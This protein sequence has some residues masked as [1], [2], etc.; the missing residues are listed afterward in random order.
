MDK[1][2]TK[3][4]TSSNSSRVNVGP[5]S[6][7]LPQPTPAKH[8]QLAKNVMCEFWRRG[9]VCRFGPNCWYAHGPMQLQAVE[10]GRM[11]NGDV[12][13]SSESA[14]Q[15]QMQDSSMNQ[16]TPEQ[17]QW[18]YLSQQAQAIIPLAQ[19][20]LAARL[21]EVYQKVRASAGM[22]MPGRTCEEIEREQKFYAAA[23]Q[24]TDSLTS[25][26]ASGSYMSGPTTPTL[27]ANWSPI[28]LDDALREQ[29]SMDLR[30]I[31]EV[32]I[33]DKAEL[34]LIPFKEEECPLYKAGQCSLD[35]ACFFKHS[36]EKYEKGKSDMKLASELPNGL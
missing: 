29:A 23:A 13:R 25:S 24:R 17:Q 20:I 32:I 34:Y 7:S 22:P 5:P 36:G 8:P 18:M 30:R 3:S 21:R 31:V 15:I 2:S 33:N 28:V 26:T 9:E 35:S 14:E 27:S 1:S 10:E 6:T 19:N 12:L 16:F 11:F 4:T